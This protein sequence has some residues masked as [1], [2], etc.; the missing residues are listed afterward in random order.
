MINLALIKFDYLI[1][2]ATAATQRAV[3][4][5]GWVIITDGTEAEAT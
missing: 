3:T 1:C 4:T 2:Y 5:T